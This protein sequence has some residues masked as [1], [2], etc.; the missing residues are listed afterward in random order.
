M[1][2]PLVVS[3]WP[4]AI[5]T[6][7]ARRQ[8]PV[9]E[10]CARV[11]L[12]REALRDHARRVPAR[13]VLQLLEACLALSADEQFGCGLRTQIGTAA[14][15]G[16]NILLDSAATLGDSL[17]CLVDCM[18]QMLGHIQPVLT[19]EGDFV[20]LTLEASLPP[21]VFGL[22]CGALALVRNSARRVGRQPGELFAE[23]RLVSGQQCVE[24]LE[25]WGIPCRRADALGLLLPVEALAW[26]QLGANTVI[27]Q[28]M[29]ASC[30]LSEANAL[31]ER[32]DL[33]RHWLRNSDQPIDSIAAR[34]GY[35]QASN[36]IRAF[37]KQYGVT[38]KQ[39]R[40]GSA[41]T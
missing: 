13:R 41:A 10:L 28:A 36:F 18:P 38:P 12:S 29:R 5:L 1:P 22:D 11:G 25:G 33:A 26:P 40:L 7:A 30:R 39:F 34:S 23:A 6:Y 16:L 32:L 17:Q 27:H 15:H 8:L 9:D 20:S 3:A 24:T 2:E 21:H 19:R 35:S 14:L 31:D 4:D 37:R